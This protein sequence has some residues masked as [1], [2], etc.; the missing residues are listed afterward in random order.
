M[1]KQTRIA[2]IIASVLILCIVGG[3]FGLYYMGLSGMHHHS[4]P[5]EG[6]I[7]VACV[8]DSITYGHGI[9][10]W[11]KNNYPT[12]LGEILGE[13]YHVENFGVS[14]TT[15]SHS[16][17]SPYTETEEYRRSLEYGADILVLML[18]TNDSKPQNFTGSAAYL[19]DLDA[20]VSSYRESNPDMKI[21]LCTPATAFFPEGVSTGRTN[22]DIQ[23]N[24]VEE[25]KYYIMSYAVSHLTEIENIID[26]HDLTSTH[27]EW[28]ETD[29]VHPSN[30]GARAI[31]ETV[32][33]KI[34]D[35]R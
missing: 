18:G 35:N 11:S 33:K 27:P 10:N 1:K 32:A 22:F 12:Q 20:L 23:P 8:G 34:T 26:I 29:L 16:G 17:D 7:K 2:I 30:E 13:G 19:A 15:L 25:I 4:S 9:T 31:A 5:S 3:G 14:G 24:A 28:F 21:Y 6:Q